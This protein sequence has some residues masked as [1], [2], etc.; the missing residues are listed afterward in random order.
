LKLKQYDITLRRLIDL[1]FKMS[2]DERGL[3]LTEAERIR[4]KL[5]ATRRSCC[6]PIVLYYGEKVHHVTITNLSFTGAFVECLI[7][8]MI[9]DAVLVEFKNFDGSEN[10]KLNARIVYTQPVW[11]SVSIL[12]LCAPMQPGFCKSAWTISGLTI[13]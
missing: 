6:I 2:L 5:R 11:G 7:P 13:Q 8:I 1:I 3:L 12:T 4:T 10:I 9:G